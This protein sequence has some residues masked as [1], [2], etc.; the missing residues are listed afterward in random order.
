M[1]LIHYRVI[2]RLNAANATYLNFGIS[3][4]N[5]KLLKLREIN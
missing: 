5:R 3:T 2:L 1:Q 4:S